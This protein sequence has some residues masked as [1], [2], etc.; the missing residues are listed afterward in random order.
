MTDDD[1][2][3]PSVTDTGGWLGPAIAR[4]IAGELED[5]REDNVIFLADYRKQT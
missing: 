1:K 3:P 5:E 2:A 4:A